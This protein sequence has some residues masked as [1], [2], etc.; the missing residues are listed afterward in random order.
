V[1]WLRHDWVPTYPLW[2]AAARNRRRD[3]DNWELKLRHGLPP[4]R[5][6]GIVA[7]GIVAKAIVAKAI[8]A[9]GSVRKVAPQPGGPYL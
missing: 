2:L 6:K 4:H 7:K 5:A 3:D 1:Y 8:V 9:K